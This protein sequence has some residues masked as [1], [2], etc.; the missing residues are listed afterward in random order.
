MNK[1]A[2]TNV[3]FIVQFH[4]FIDDLSPHGIG[5]PLVEWFE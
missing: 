5:A 1:A 2:G 4:V 3:G